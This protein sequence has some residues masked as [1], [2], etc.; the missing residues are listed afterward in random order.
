MTERS[1]D[2]IV[3]VGTIGID[4][5]DGP[6]GKAE[7]VLGGSAFFATTAAAKLAPASLIAVVGGDL[8]EEQW[9]NLSANKDENIDLSGVQVVKDGSTF[10]WGCIYRDDINRRDTTFTELGVLEAFDPVVPENLKGASSVLLAN[11]VPA[12][13]LRL[14]DQLTAPKFVVLDTMNFWI[15]GMRDE[16]EKVI[17]RSNAMILNDDEARQ[18]TGKLNLVTALKD[19]RA[20][21]PDVVIIKKGEHGAMMSAYDDIFSIPGL[22]IEQVKDPTGAGD[23]FAGGFVGYLQRAGSYDIPAL[24]SAVAYG[25]ALASFC[26]EDFSAQR[27]WKADKAELESRV[28]QFRKLVEFK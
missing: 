21:G 8:T 10:R 14:L 1:S 28:D 3:I 27:L 15:S 24:R 5:I 23:C 12:V 18:L 16:L 17:A 13:Q 6:Y 20:M 4:D 26:C 7:R 22:P 25:S 11:V 9:N 19:I 2:K